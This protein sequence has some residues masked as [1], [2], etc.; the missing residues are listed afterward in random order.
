METGQRRIEGFFQKPQFANQGDAPEDQAAT[1]ENHPQSSSKPFK[2]KRSDSIAPGVTD[3]DN[4]QE[5]AA[6]QSFSRPATPS[7][8]CDR[9]GQSISP[10][11]GNHDVPVAEDEMQQALERLRHEHDDFHFAQ[12]LSN[13]APNGPS[14]KRATIRPSDNASQ[15]AKSKKRKQETKDRGK[16]AEDP[17]GGIAKFFTQR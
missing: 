16:A 1:S 3:V 17:K 6:R 12:D 14:I 2:R 8:V 9:C 10:S 11:Y 5:D 4:A 15:P 13:E 7:Y